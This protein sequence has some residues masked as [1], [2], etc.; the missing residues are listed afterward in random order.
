MGQTKKAKI[1]SEHQQKL[2]LLFLGRTRYPE[3]NK[4]IF[5]LSCHGG[6]RA[7]EIALLEWKD[8]LNDESSDI[9]DEIEITNSISKGDDGGRIVEMTGDLIT[10]LRDHYHSYIIKPRHDHRVVLNQQGVA[11]GAANVCLLFYRWYKIM[12]FHGYSSHSGRRT[13]ITSCARRV[14]LHGCSLLDVQQMVGHSSLETT[15]G[16]IEKNKEG[17]RNLMKSFKSVL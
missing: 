6:L 9:T 10:V 17:R 15:Q 3:R 14:A 11:M 2:M 12:N 8:V 16:Y 7:K 13:F 1:L 4:V 5:L